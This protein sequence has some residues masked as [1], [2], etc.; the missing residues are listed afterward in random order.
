[1]TDGGDDDDGDDVPVTEPTLPQV[2]VP[3]LDAEDAVCRAWSR[4][5]GSFQVAA[6]AASFADQPVAAARL[7]V[8]ASPVVA[9]AVDEMIDNWPESLAD[10]AE[11]AA[12]GLIGPYARRSERA[13][14]LL[15]EAG[16][17]AADLDRLSEIWLDSLAVRDPAEVLPDLVLPDDL[18]RLVDVA[19]AEFDAQVVAIPDD[20]SLVTDVELPATEA[21][22]AGTCPDRGTLA[23]GEP[24]E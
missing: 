18:A 8:V 1:G 24:V 3:G 2:G 22:L 23:G 14:D 16:A 12:D 11:L 6:V 20:P 15:V 9:T 7:E 4:F 17:E 13:L 19:T 5:A 10:E 21:F